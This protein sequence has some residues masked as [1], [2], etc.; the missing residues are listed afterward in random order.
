MLSSDYCRICTFLILLT[1][2]FECS[3]LYSKKSQHFLI[4]HKCLESF[5]CTPSLYFNYNTFTLFS[6]CHLPENQNS[7]SQFHKNY[8]VAVSHYSLHFY[9]VLLKD[10]NSEALTF[11]SFYETCLVSSPHYQSLEYISIKY[12]EFSQFDVTESVTNFIRTRWNLDQ[13]ILINSQALE[14]FNYQ[15]QFPISLQSKDIRY[16]Q[17]NVSDLS[18]MYFITSGY[19][20]QCTHKN[21]YEKLASLTLNFNAYDHN[22]RLWTTMY[23]QKIC[24]KNLHP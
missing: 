14:I 2:P 18:L 23:S 22:K 19:G 21:L 16:K 6:Y 17:N 1:N 13:I 8:F 12:R 15:G 9:T 10:I 20:Q 4:A 3:F 11:K 24:T 7:T 5:S